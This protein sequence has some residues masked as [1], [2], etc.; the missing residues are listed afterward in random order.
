MKQTDAEI[1][2]KTAVELISA[3]KDMGYNIIPFHED[4][5]KGFFLAKALSSKG[6]DRQT[7]EETT[8]IV[9]LDIS[10]TVDDLIHG[11]I[12]PLIAKRNLNSTFLSALKHSKGEFDGNDMIE[13]GKHCFGAPSHKVDWNLLLQQYRTRK[14][15]GK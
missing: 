10:K 12:H 4:A 8:Q 1:A 9:E 6:E 3:L 15:G 13:F 5:I 11:I 7:D 14:D 2:E